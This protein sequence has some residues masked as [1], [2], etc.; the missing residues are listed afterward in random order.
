MPYNTIQRVN[1]VKKQGGATMI[2]MAFVAAA[3][4]FVAI[5]AMKMAPSYMEYF[6]VKTVLKAMAQESLSSMSKKE[7]MNS[8]D[9]RRNVAYVEIVKGDDLI[10][11]KNDVGATV[12][13]VQY[14]VIK[15]I[16]A[17]VSVL[18]E[19]NASSDAK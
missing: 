16:V 4:I 5:I 14:Q 10:I 13:S 1:S 2:G 15:P 8:F 12:V 17:N 3:V 6:S 19:F 11:E 9:K 7:I 18:M